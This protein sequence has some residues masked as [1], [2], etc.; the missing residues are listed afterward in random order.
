[1]SD[2][3]PGDA[4]KKTVKKRTI[5]VADSDFGKV[6]AEVSTAWNANNWLTLKWLT[7]ADFA[8]NSGL[9]NTTLSARQLSGGARPQVAKELK[10]LNSEIDGALTIVKGYLLEKFR[11]KDTAASYYKSFGMERV[12]GRFTFPSDQS[13]RQ[14]AFELMLQALPANGLDGKDYGLAYWTGLRDSYVKLV[15]QG[16]ALDGGISEKVG[17]K[18]ELKKT[19]KKGLNAVINVIKGNYPDTY[20]QELRNWGLQKE[21]Y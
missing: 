7:A 5:P 20:K 9:Y 15:S 12:D 11:K 18:N 21:K 19:L 1:M 17:D 16:R 4:P 6:I 8:T 2:E 13:N 3:Q 10:E 14:D